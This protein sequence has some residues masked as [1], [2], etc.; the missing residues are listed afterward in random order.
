MESLHSPRPSAGA[1][2]S[3]AL[4]RAA[5]LLGLSAREL[6]AVIG[7]SEASLSRLKKG[8]AA[9][10]LAGKPYELALLFIR[11]YRS[12]DAIMGGDDEASR[13]WMRAE[14]TALGGRPISRITTIDGLANVLAYLDAR[15]APV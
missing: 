4:M 14:N 2:A 5:E 13:R 3:K 11:L 7:L 10:R 8:D 12:L 1:V 9:V 15:R 6:S